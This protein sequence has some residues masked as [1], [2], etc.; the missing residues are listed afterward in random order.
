MQHL[1]RSSQQEQQLTVRLQVLGESR[2]RQDRDEAVGLDVWV[3]F[4][5]HVANNH[6]PASSSCN[7]QGV[8][9]HARTTA[10]VSK[11]D[12]VDTSMSSEDAIAVF[13]GLVRSIA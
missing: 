12:D 3:D 6:C 4:G 5:V 11:D 1:E 2:Y 9:L 7:A 8:I 13:M 10:N